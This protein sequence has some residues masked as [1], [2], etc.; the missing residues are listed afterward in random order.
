MGLFSRKKKVNVSVHGMPAHASALD[1]RYDMQKR[2]Q[3]ELKRRKVEAL[4]LEPRSAK[5]LLHYIEDTYQVKELERTDERYKKA[6][7]GV[8][9][10]LVEEYHPELIKTPRIDPPDHPPLSQ[11]DEDYKNWQANENLRF[12][13]AVMLKNDVFPVDLHVFNL[14][15][16]IKDLHIAWLEVYVETRYDYLAFNTI[17]LEYEEHYSI[18][19]VKKDIIRYF[20]AGEADKEADNERYRQLI[21]IL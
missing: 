1:G 21:S 20:G 9:A 12:R 4:A 14:D 15:I 5:E 3:K 7:I 11:D 8:K 13:E 10:H 17:A 19:K 2:I 6:Y 16:A 18:D